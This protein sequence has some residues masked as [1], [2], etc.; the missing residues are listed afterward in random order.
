MAGDRKP[1]I[2]DEEILNATRLGL[3]KRM[4]E[5]KALAYDLAVEAQKFQARLRNTE[6]EIMKIEND[7][8]ILNNQEKTKLQEVKKNE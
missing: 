8:L 2:T 6:S 4:T 3:I 1:E 5:A 7:L